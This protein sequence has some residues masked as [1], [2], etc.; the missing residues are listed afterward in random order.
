[1]TVI[2][3]W[4]KSPGIDENVTVAV[5]APR[6]CREMS[7]GPESGAHELPEYHEYA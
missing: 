4:A 7:I 2:R 1:M 3:R 6:V 5:S